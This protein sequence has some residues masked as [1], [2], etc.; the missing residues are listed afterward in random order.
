MA[1]IYSYPLSTPKVKDLLIGT[2]V[3][4]KELEGSPRNNPTVSFTVQSIVDLIAPKTGLQGLQSVTSVGNTTTNPIVINSGLS[5]LTTFTDSSGSV[6]TAGQVLSS[7]VIGTSWIADTTGNNYFVTGAAFNTGTGVL[8]ITGNNAAVGATVDLDGRYIRSNETITLTGDITGSGTTAITTTLNTVNSNVGSFTNADITVNG[9]GL[10]TAAAS[11]TASGVSKIVA[12][13][14]ITITPAT[15][16]GDVTINSA[17]APVTSLTTTGTSGASSL[18]ALGVLN[19]PDYSN[20]SDVTSFTN[21]NGTYVSSSVV[22]TVATGSVTVGTIDLSAVDGPATAITPFLTKTNYWATPFYTSITSTDGT[23]IDLTPNAPIAGAI[24]ITAD[25]S[26]VDGPSDVNT[27]FLSKDNTWD[28]PTY[29][30]TGVTSFTNTNGTYVSAAIANVDAT[31]TVTTGIIDLSAVDG[32]A[33]AATRFLSKDNTWDVPLFPSEIDTLQ[34][35]TTRG[36]TTNKSITMNGSGVDGNLYVTGNSGPSIPSHSQ[37]IALAYNNSAGQRESEL[38]W[39]TGGGSNTPAINNASYF[40]IY[41]EFIDSTAGNARVTNNQVKL[42]GTGSLELTRPNAGLIT[43]HFS[44]PIVA[45]AQNSL[46]ARSNTKQTAFTTTLSY[47][48]TN[49]TLAILPASGT[50]SEIQ[51]KSANNDIWKLVISNAGALVITGPF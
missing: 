3:F 32:T 30:S 43:P 38:F 7:T 20:S 51:M 2:N 28:V 49:A 35:V 13:D 44:S 45:G 37:G 50:P 14:R 31:G 48:E 22:N 42:Y 5:V 25:L 39:N 6:G 41:N 16:L 34:S 18:S 4:D 19:V 46:L 10:I 12:G 47:N 17:I 36:N 15:G 9:K 29:T 40:G 24:T 8:S 21:I 11:G 23:Y 26:A 33:V 27:R 1:I